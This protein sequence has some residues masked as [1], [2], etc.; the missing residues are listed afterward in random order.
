MK[1]NY[2]IFIGLGLLFSCT[3]E[4][5]RPNILWISHEDF[6][7]AWGC[8]G[9][10]QAT[11]PNIDALAADGYLFEQ[12]FSNAP[13][14]APARATLISGMFATSYGTQNLRSE[15]PRPEGF[16]TLPEYFREQGY[17]T[18]NNAKTDYNFSPEGLWDDLGNTA[19]WRNR[20]GEQPFF[21]VYNAMITHEGHT[22]RYVAE[23]T[24]SVNPKHKPEDMV[25]P[26]YF[27]DTPE[28]K[29]IMAHQYDL[30]T[31]FDQKVG[32]II[33][34]LKEDGEYENTIIM[35]F[36]DHGHGLPRYKR[37]L[38]DTGLR[39]PFIMHVPE[40]FKHLVSNI[41]K[42]HND[43]N[44][45]FVDF[46]PTVLKLAGIDTPDIMEGDNFLGS[47]SNQD[48][49]SFGYRDRA[50]DSYDMSR[51]VFDGRY[52][53]IRN[54][55]PHLPY[56]INA[57]IY[58]PDK[59]SY[60]EL[61][62]ARDA[63]EL[64]AESMKMF[65][66]KPFEEL[67]DLE[68]DPQELRNVINDE[69]LS[70]VAGKL[71]ERLKKHLIETHDTGLMNE[72]HMM[73]LAKENNTSVYEMAGNTKFFDVNEALNAA[74]NVGRVSEIEELSKLLKSKNANV[75][76]WGLT[77]L[78]NPEIKVDE[79]SDQLKEMLNDASEPN[80]YLAAEILINK[81]SEN[82]EAYA[83]LKDEL[84]H[85]EYEPMTLQL[86]I[87]IRNLDKK[88]RPL[89]PT[90]KEYAYPKI[91]GDVGRGGYKS[92]SYPMFIGFAYDQIIQNCL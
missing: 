88:A 6:S 39:V 36:S 85:Q 92:W 24:K 83:L 31:V 58:G 77:A 3:S 84:I 67:Y 91:K 1:F 37:W 40:K 64:S 61:L 62:R 43:L 25:I 46:A 17:F 34:E 5:E 55:M 8:Y 53:Y 11:T 80:R 60:K 63:G 12:A 73:L 54:Y 86:A 2:L 56:I 18:S 72:G 41:E 30:M 59:W 9:D 33:K 49:Y 20:A 90:L 51:S 45:S 76:F 68:Q 16:K 69:A 78:Q 29:K 23:D 38:Y 47:E 65:L 21:S 4:E 52:M 42:G 71:K 10:E 35:V 75:R 15:I 81:T 26:P 27:P 57:Q 74:E 50:D 89:L 44:V 82:K 48:A 28:F 79:I 7:P 32:E 22:N 14:C 87:A 19:H 66:P 70:G 13:I